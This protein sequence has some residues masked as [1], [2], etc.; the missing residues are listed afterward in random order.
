M[1]IFIYLI[2]ATLFFHPYWTFEGQELMKHF[3]HFFKNMAMMGGMVFIMTHGSGS[4]SI[5]NI[6]KKPES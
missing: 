5:D 1:I 6:F 3:H 4:L 2:P